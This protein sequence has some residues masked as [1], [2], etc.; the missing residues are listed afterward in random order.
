M[1]QTRVAAI[2]ACYQ[3]AL[4]I[5]RTPSEV[6]A[7]PFIPDINIKCE[8]IRKTILDSVRRRGVRGNYARSLHTCTEGE[9]RTRVC[10][11]PSS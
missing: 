6:A 3:H 9:G 2:V 7:H 10:E 8:P 11:G 1:R 5:T 4:L